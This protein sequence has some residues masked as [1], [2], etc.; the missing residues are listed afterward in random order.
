MLP[1]SSKKRTYGPFRLGVFSKP[2]GVIAIIGGVFIVWVGLQPPTSILISYFLGII[3]LLLVGWFV[4]N[5]GASPG[6]RSAKPLLR[7]RQQHI[8]EEETAVG[9]VTSQPSKNEKQVPASLTNGDLSMKLS[10]FMMPLH[11][12]NR[13][14]LTTLEEDIEAFLL[15][16]ELGFDE[17]W[18][19]EHYS[20]DIEQISSPLIFLALYQRADQEYETRY[21]RGAACRSIIR[22]SLPRIPPCW[23]I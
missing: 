21:R 8:L 12:M 5:A 4:S 20:S 10:L 6:R 7:A 22:R 9:E 11:T 19:G 1:C 2:L 17:G 16:E 23:T 14:Y 15:A 18:V 13:L 3:G